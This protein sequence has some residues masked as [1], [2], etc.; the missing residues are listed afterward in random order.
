MS[1][2]RRTR[3]ISFR[4]SETEF[5]ELRTRSEGQGA[6]SVSDYARL[7]LRDSTSTPDTRIEADLDQLSS[8]VQRLSSEVRRLTDLLEGKPRQVTNGHSPVQDGA[9]ADA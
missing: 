2:T 5:Q 1:F 3:M 4:V 9:S 8:E 7:A 6:R